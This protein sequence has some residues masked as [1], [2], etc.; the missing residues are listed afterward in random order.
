[1]GALPAYVCPTCLPGAHRS[2]KKTSDPVEL[3]L[4]MVVSYHENARNRTC[5]L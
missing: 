1:M 3:K 5:D 2:Q 4:Q